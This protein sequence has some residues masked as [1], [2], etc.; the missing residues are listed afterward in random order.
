MRVI[1]LGTD[2]QAP[3]STASLDPDTLQWIDLDREELMGEDALPS[4][5]G[6]TLHQRHLRDIANSLPLP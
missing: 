3:E 2:K 6:R 1:R 4:F 5:L